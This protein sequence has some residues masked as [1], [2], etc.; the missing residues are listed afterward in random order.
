MEQ[1]RMDRYDKFKAVSLV[2]GL[3]TDPTF[4]ANTVR[5]DILIH[6]LISNCN[7]T[8]TPT[9]ATIKYWLNEY[10]PVAMSSHME[11]P[12]EDSF[13]SRVAT[14][15]GDFRVYGGIWDGYSFYLPLILETIKTLPSHFETSTLFQP[16]KALLRLSDEIVKR[17]KGRLNHIAVSE[18]KTVIQLPSLAQL[19]RKADS[20]YF[21]VNDI[22]LLGFLP[23]DLRPFVLYE[24]RFAL[25]KETSFGNSDLV[26]FPL[27]YEGDKIL[28]LHPSCISWAIRFFVFR[29]L[30]EKSLIQK[31]HERL[32]IQY[33]N[34]MQ[35]LPA[36]GRFVPRQMPYVIN[37]PA[38]HDAFFFEFV[39]QYDQTK[40]IHFIVKVDSLIGL[41]ENGISEFPSKSKHQQD[42]IDKRIH[43]CRELILK[44]NN[45]KEGFTIVVLA[46]YGRANMYAVQSTPNDWHVAAINAYDLQTLNWTPNT[47]ETTLY[48]LVKAKRHIESL[49]TKFSNPNGLLNLYGWW[50]VSDEMMVPLQVK[51]G[52]D[53]NK[54]IN[55]PTDCLAALRRNSWMVVDQRMVPFVDG[56]L[57]MV[58]KRNVNSYFTKSRDSRLYL[59]FSDF[60]H[61]EFSGCALIGRKPWWIGVSDNKPTLNRQLIFRIYDAMLYW[62][63]HIGTQLRRK[64][65]LGSEPILFE[66]DFSEL[67]PVERIDRPT[68]APYNEIVTYEVDLPNNRILLILKQPFQ[69]CLHNPLNLSE[70]ALV[71][72]AVEAYVE[73]I[74]MDQN[75]INIQNTV[76]SIIPNNYSR[77]IHFFQGKNFRENIAHFFYS[78]Y[79]VINEF[80]A[81]IPRIGLGHFKSLGEK[82]IIGKENCTKY[83]NDLV[84]HRYKLLKN[85]L[86]QYDRG[87]L[88]FR[89]LSNI[90]ALDAERSV[91]E[92]TARAVLNLHH[93]EEEI[94]TGKIKH[95]A[96]LHAADIA[97]R[98]LIEIGICEAPILGDASKVGE[99]DLSPL[100]A[101]ASL[102]FHFGNLSD[103]ID[104]GVIA[105]DILVPPNGDVRFEQTFHEGIMQPVAGKR[106]TDITIQNAK[107][108]EKNFSAP[109][110]SV[111]PEDYYPIAFLNACQQ[112]FGVSIDNILDFMEAIQDLG[113]TKEKRVY[114][115]PLGN[116][117]IHC[118]TYQ[119]LSID[120]V[121]KILNAFSLAPRP[122]WETPPNGYEG[123]DIYPWLFRRRLSMLMK[124]LLRID[125]TNDPCYII[126]PGFFADAI[127][128][129]IDLYRR[130]GI[131][132]LRCN[133]AAMKKWIGDE[134][135][136]R[137]KDFT[138]KVAAALRNLGY[139]VLTE[140]LVSS[141]ISSKSVQRNFGDIDIIAWKNDSLSVHLI[142]CKNLLF[143]K[144][145]SEMAEQLQDYKGSVHSD[146]SPD[147]LRRHIDRV[148]IIERHLPAFF[149]YLKIDKTKHISSHLIFSH[150]VPVIYNK[151]LKVSVKIQHLQEIEDKG[152]L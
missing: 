57:K 69:Y 61:S 151:E 76:D 2:A 121:R 125:D 127:A 38:I 7:G 73:L 70:R 96:S 109:G 54:I 86:K 140:V 80:D 3:L 40:F 50:K 20:L 116:V 93:G 18:P 39:T 98:M 143:A 4:H 123:R 142:E 130:G 44:E 122:R 82:R 138:N 118:S 144:T 120:I 25:V 45:I 145:I 63:E 28:V 53:Q 135:A 106:E 15:W 137:G 99:L 126:S 12:V 107:D 119:K 97:C 60:V 24:P 19:Q 152:I 51:I 141:I 49:K 146:G 103:G 33:Y 108:Y 47:D 1:Y 128:Y 100:M 133:S 58:R 71:R 148:Q 21:S 9:T 112:E 78:K 115:I 113:F 26:R 75:A 114:G 88:V 134:R 94:F 147:S 46:G 17:N 27:T 131:D 105:A 11:D 77:H 62:I 42:E 136:K 31:F 14:P 74:G 149:K 36:L 84:A 22:I 132:E 5:I 89:L 111:S 56:S 10:P 13:I 85:E 35:E 79:Y 110:T 124:P 95:F 102:I 16:I 65:E 81:A 37:R 8:E 43:R 87:E 48:R 104:K 55:I 101:Q 59:D 30:G 117:L 139:E 23:D 91:W 67:Q 52:D 129:T 150:A 90:E 72:T 64:F 41:E 83:I 32:I 92:R 68:T 29:W 34:F 66:L 6:L